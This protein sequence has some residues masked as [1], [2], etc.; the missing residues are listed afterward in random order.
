VVALLFA[1]VSG[2]AEFRR[3][4]EHLGLQYQDNL[5]SRKGIR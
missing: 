4:S 5:G 2:K 3:A 1:N